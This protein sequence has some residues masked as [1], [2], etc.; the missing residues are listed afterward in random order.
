MRERPVLPRSP[1]SSA[2][3]GPGARPVEIGVFEK[4]HCGW[5]ERLSAG[6]NVGWVWGDC[7]K[8]S[9]LGERSEWSLVFTEGEQ[10]GVQT[11]R[12]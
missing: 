9:G 5:R 12:T 4:D 3:L 10:E 2:H 6:S 1:K 8:G 7:A 11:M